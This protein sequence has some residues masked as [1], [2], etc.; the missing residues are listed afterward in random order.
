MVS[1][2]KYVSLLLGEVVFLLPSEFTLR[3]LEMRIE[4]PV[5]FTAPSLEEFITM[6]DVLLI[7]ADWLMRSIFWIESSMNL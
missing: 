6:R 2:R 7:L 3:I 5:R 4:R 1:F